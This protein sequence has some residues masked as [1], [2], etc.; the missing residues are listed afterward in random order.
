MSRFL[1]G[2]KKAQ[3]KTTTHN[4]ALTL[5]STQ[6]SVLDFFSQA[7]SM[8]GQDI[9]KLFGN[10]FAENRA[11]ATAALFKLRDVRGG[12]GERELF[13]KG[14]AQILDVDVDVFK[15]IFR[16]VPEYGRWDDL[17]QFVKHEEVGQEVTDFILES[18]EL[19]ISLLQQGNGPSL[20]AK[21]MPSENASSR[22][23][24]QL[25]AYFIG[26]LGWSA[27][28]YRKTLSAL[29]AVLNIVE[30]PMSANKW[31]SINYSR[32]TSRAAKLYRKAFGR[33]DETRYK[34]FIEKAIKGEVKINSS[35]LYPYEIV[36]KLRR[37]SDKTLEALWNQLPDLIKDND[38][39]AIAVI[40]TSGSMESWSYYGGTSKDAPKSY[41]PYDVA[42]SLGLYFAERSK[43]P[44]KNH[45]ITFNSTAE[46]NELRGKSLYEKL[47]SVPCIY[48]ST[49]LQ[50][51][52]NLILN[53]G[54]KNQLSNDEMPNMIFILSDGEF[55]PAS[56]GLTNFETI[57]KKYQ[58]AGYEMPKLVSWRIAVH[59]EQAPAT[60]LQ[61]NIFCVSGHSAAAFKSC[62][63]S[64]AVNPLG[65]MLEVLNS[66]RYK[67]IVDALS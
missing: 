5:K 25:A 63:E 43:G 53:T 13:R 9:S 16:F 23:T 20:L 48:G 66:E 2:A 28:R 47:K 36:S 41:S 22:K 6:N 32:V 33:H 61:N 50:S 14:L 18:F 11:L 38:K 30:R 21:W 44:F 12:S 49:N 8:R 24:H 27:A 35:T 52:F 60:E 55:N 19:D 64:K 54:I 57:E 10:A 1:S 67:P 59:K 42:M 7:D 29:R 58:A 4:G 45:Y 39:R 17:F 37:S 65:L 3:N 56:P 31:D 40:D 15:K 46:L 51:V 62:I 34:A 26:E